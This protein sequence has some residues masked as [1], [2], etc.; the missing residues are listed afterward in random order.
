MFTIKTILVS[1]LSVFYVTCFDCFYPSI[2][3]PL[4]RAWR[5]IKFLSNINSN[6]CEVSKFELKD[7]FLEYDKYLNYLKFSS[8]CKLN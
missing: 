6:M 1:K 2:L 4:L 7:C 3:Y 5:S 8:F